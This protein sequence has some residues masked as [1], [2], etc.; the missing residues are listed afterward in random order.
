MPDSI[1]Q[2]R[3]P[4]SQ[5]A[6]LVGQLPCLPHHSRLLAGPSSMLS[7]ALVHAVG[8]VKPGPGT[9]REGSV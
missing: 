2:H 5:Q 9:A 7:A 3:G 6:G 4:N 1:G 8:H